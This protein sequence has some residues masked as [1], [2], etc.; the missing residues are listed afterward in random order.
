MIKI[1]S[2]VEGRRFDLYKLERL[3]KPRGYTIGGNWDYDHGSFDYKLADDDGYHFLRLP[4]RAIDGQ[5]DMNHCTVELGRP[6][7]LSHIYQR[8]LDDHAQTGNMS[9]SFN[10][11]AEPEDKDGQFPEKYIAA[12]K[13]LVRELEMLLVD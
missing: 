1:P 8:G 2:S 10:Q 4:F 13:E 11:F 12:G 9:A 7:L 5:L 6:F 3:L